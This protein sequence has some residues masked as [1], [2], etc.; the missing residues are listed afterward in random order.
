VGDIEKAGMRA[1]PIVFGNDAFGV[2]HGH[3]ITGERDKP[4][5]QLPMPLV[6][7]RET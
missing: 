3:F 7:G 5:R 6:K 4:G 1:R 2:L